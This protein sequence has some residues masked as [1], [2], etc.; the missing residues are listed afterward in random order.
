MSTNQRNA[1]DAQLEEVG[2]N[3]AARGEGGSDIDYLLHV[4]EAVEAFTRLQQEPPNDLIA[5]ILK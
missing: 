5:I 4:L 3:Q 2:D 1:V